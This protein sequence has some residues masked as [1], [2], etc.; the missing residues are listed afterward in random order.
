MDLLLT[1]LAIAL[2]GAVIY[3]LVA[4]VWRFWRKV[5][6]SEEAGQRAMKLAAQ[7]D[8]ERRIRL[9]AERGEKIPL[10]RRD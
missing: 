4:W 9:S 5:R 6:Y 1:Y 8:E 7:Q 10:N 3:A 2:W